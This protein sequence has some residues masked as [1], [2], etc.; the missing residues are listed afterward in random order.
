MFRQRVWSSGIRSRVQ[1]LALSDSAS[2]GPHP[3][4]IGRLGLRTLG[5]EDHLDYLED[6]MNPKRVSGSYTISGFIV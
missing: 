2:S 3:F 1:G 5:S 4:R 6:E